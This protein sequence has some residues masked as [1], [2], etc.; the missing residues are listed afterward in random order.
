M[1][2]IKKFDTVSAQTEYLENAKLDTYV[3]YVGETQDVYYDDAIPVGGG[4]DLGQ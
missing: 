4:N 2:Y 1:K 3:G